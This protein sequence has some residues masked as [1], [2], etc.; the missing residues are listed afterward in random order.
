MQIRKVINTETVYTFLE[1]SFLGVVNTLKSEGKIIV[2][3]LIAGEGQTAIF[4]GNYDRETVYTRTATEIPVVFFQT[5]LYYQKSVGSLN[6]DPNPDKNEFNP[7]YWVKKDIQFQLFRDQA[8]FDGTLKVNTYSEE[9]ETQ[10]K[11]YGLFRFLGGEVDTNKNMNIYLHRYSFEMLNFEIYRDDIKVI[12]NAMAS[13]MNGNANIL[14]DANGIFTSFAT[15]SEFPTLSEEI[16]ANGDRKFISTVIIDLLFYTDM[17]H[18]TDTIFLLDGVQ[19]PYTEVRMAR[20]MEEPTP[21]IT[22]AFES[23]YLPTRSAFSLSLTGY[24]QVNDAVESIA[25]WLLDETKLSYPVRF[26]YTDGYKVKTGV[27]LIDTLEFSYPYQGLITYGLNL[28]PLL[29]PT[30]THYGV[31]AKNA[32]GTGEY[33]VGTQVQL[34]SE[35][36]N[37]T[38]WTVESGNL[39]LS[40]VQETANPLFFTMP[41]TDVIIKANL[42]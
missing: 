16:D 33:E 39:V 28:I 40:E 24:Y 42:G 41:E 4:M 12:L 11:N 38:S 37:F 23:T 5:H 14:T 34:N 7:E 25:D 30:R 8:D 17:I 3:T 18:S 22:K 36:D 21:N 15:V 2:D 9:D 29:E 31:L 13:S 27:Y 19:I 35:D 26:F 1:N 32:I 10:K 20:K 6:T